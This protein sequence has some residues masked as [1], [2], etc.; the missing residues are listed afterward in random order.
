MM[1]PSMA[2]KMLN[3]DQF[4]D[5]QS[6]ILAIQTKDHTN[7]ELHYLKSRSRNMEVCNYGRKTRDARR[8]HFG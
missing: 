3:S 2:S 7:G 4:S 5:A 6:L 1:Q 8:T